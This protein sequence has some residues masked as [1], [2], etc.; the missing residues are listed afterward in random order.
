MSRINKRGKRDSRA[1]GNSQIPLQDLETLLPGHNDVSGHIQEQAVFDD[2]RTVGQ[3]SGQAIQIHNAFGEQQ[4]R[5][6]VSIVSDNEGAI[7]FVAEFGA[8]AK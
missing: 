6:K 2:A 3:L 7:F 8:A 1:I 5:L 4:H